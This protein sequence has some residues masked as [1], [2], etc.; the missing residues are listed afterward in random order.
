MDPSPVYGKWFSQD[1]SCKG[2][3]FG[4]YVGW[5]TAQPGNGMVLIYRNWDTCRLFEQYV[6]KMP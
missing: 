6:K 1:I 5:Q 4:Q 3:L 2:P